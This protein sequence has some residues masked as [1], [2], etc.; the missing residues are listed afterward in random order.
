MPRSNYKCSSWSKHHYQ[1]A[2]SL[3]CKDCNLLGLDQCK[4]YIQKRIHHKSTSLGYCTWSQGKCCDKTLYQVRR[5]FRSSNRCSYLTWS[6][7][8]L[9]SSRGNENI[10]MAC[11]Q[12][13][14]NPPGTNLD[15]SIHLFSG[16]QDPLNWQDR[17]GNMTGMMFLC[18]KSRFCSSDDNQS[19]NLP[20]QS[21]V[22]IAS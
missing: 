21:V 14:S 17:Q 2:K 20:S 11:L 15:T 8:N 10:W 6:H 16:K 9:R 22:G 18:Q 12:E 7:H 13:R 19:N 3:S 5:T 4:P 1:A